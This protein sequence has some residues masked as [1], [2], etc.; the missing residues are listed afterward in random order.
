M[1]I[2]GQDNLLFQFKINYT[3]AIFHSISQIF[4]QILASSKWD[5]LE[6][7]MTN[8]NVQKQKHWQEFIWKCVIYL[9][10]KL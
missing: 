3:I 2:I 8:Q 9:S 10:L 1:N 4:E 5:S 7:L 6:T